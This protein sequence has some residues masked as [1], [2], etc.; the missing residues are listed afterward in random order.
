MEILKSNNLN[1]NDN[2]KLIYFNE[3]EG[4]FKSTQ[5]FLIKISIIL[6][7][8][9]T[10][11]NYFDIR[12]QFALCFLLLMVSFLWFFQFLTKIFNNNFLI[13]SLEILFFFIFFD[14]RYI[15]YFNTFFCKSLA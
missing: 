13:A 14:I 12:F 6:D 7:D 5:N 1:F 8:I 9:F 10:K 11:D 2:N 4:N 15:C 3:A